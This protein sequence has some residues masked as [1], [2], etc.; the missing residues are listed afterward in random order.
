[1]GPGSTSRDLDYVFVR[2]AACASD[3]AT[4]KSDGTDTTAV[5]QLGFAVLTAFLRRFKAVVPKKLRQPKAKRGG[6]PLG[7][8]NT[9]SQDDNI[10]VEVNLH[11]LPLLDQLPGPAVGTIEASSAS[12][13][14]DNH[15]K[16]GKY[17]AL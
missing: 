12:T 5:E 15:I 7:D 2:S 9:S 14:I 3:S 8:P 11:A 10:W 1:M 17:P 13:D 6:K 16:E 4:L